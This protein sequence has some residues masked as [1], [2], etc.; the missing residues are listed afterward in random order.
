MPEIDR[1]LRDSVNLR[2]NLIHCARRL[3]ETGLTK[4][5]TGNLSHRVEGGLL[6][7]PTGMDYDRLEPDDIVFVAMD[8]TPTGR[9]LPSSE[10]RFH[11]DILLER[12]EVAVVLHAHAPFATSLACLREGIPAFHYMVA[13]AGGA[14]IRCAPYATFGTAELSAHA[15]AALSGRRACLLANH[16]MIALGHDFDRALKLA[17]EIEALAEMYW[18][19]RQIGAPVI[20]DDDEMARVIEKF[21]T[22]GKQPPLLDAVVE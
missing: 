14:D 11:R 6:V 20:L 5:T 18:R 21:R 16:G 8:G 3:T 4:N 15:V 7:T 17:V 2:R 10:W 22:Y 9:R 19:A 12:P 1:S 13:V